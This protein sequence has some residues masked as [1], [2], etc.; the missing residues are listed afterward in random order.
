[1]D[2]NEVVKMH[3]AAL[4]AAPTVSVSAKVWARIVLLASGIF[5]VLVAMGDLIVKHYWFGVITAHLT[6]MLSTDALA[7][8]YHLPHLATATKVAIFC[9]FGL[10]FFECFE[11]YKHE[12]ALR[13][14]KE[15][16]TEVTH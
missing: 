5:A 16:G 8:V 15:S 1:M 2:T 4:C 7:H 12:K 9:D 3:R 14:A 6:V 10:L 11:L 13:E